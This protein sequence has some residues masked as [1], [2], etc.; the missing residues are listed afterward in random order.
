MENKKFA[1]FDMDGTLI[2]SM[3]YWK[4]LAKEY[5]ESKDIFC[6]ME[7]IARIIKPMTMTESAKYFVERFKMNLDEKTVE[8]EMNS[9][10]EKHYIEDIPLKPCVREYLEKLKAKDIKM[11]VA[12]ATT[13]WLI[14][15]CLKRLGILDFFEFTI[16][17][18]EVFAGKDSPAVFLKCAEIFNEKPENIL[19]F[20]DALYAIKTATDANFYTIG[21]NDNFDEERINK[22]KNTADYYINSFCEKI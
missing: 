18:E 20:E 3:P 4:N 1:I 16:S 21:V 17:C 11:C 22:I 2:D 19:V 5:L 7:E 12:S 8:A 10:I 6:D 13:K 15:S 9:M 14:D